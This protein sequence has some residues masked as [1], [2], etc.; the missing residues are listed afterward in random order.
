[1]SGLP[2]V[3]RSVVKLGLDLSPIPLDIGDGV[4]WKFTSD[5]SPE[6]WSSLM[7]ALKV[8]TTLKDDADGDESRFTKALSDFSIAMSN[9]LLDPKQQA[10]WVERGYGLVPQQAVSEVLMETWSGFPTKQQ[11]ESGTESKKT[12]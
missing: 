1:M 9:M 7:A 4:V 8:F 10:E 11:S 12:G 5:P 3:T 6:Q 2:E